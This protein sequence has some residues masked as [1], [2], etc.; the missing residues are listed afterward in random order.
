MLQFTGSC[1]KIL[2]IGI[3]Q[4]YTISEPL[5]K[6]IV[7]LALSHLIPSLPRLR[8]LSFSTHPQVLRANSCLKHSDNMFLFQCLLARLSSAAW[9]VI[10]LV[11]GTVGIVFKLQ[12]L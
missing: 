5:A 2:K 1:A 7:S 3:S 12:S 4:H 11:S 6:I 9:Y 8:I 10:Y